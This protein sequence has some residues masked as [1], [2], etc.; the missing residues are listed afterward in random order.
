MI[1]IISGDFFN[2]TKPRISRYF[3]KSHRFLVL[4]RMTSCQQLRSSLCNWAFSN[5]FCS[6][7]AVMH[8]F[9]SFCRSLQS[10]WFTSINYFPHT[11]HFQKFL[12]PVFRCDTGSPNLSEI[13]C[14]TSGPSPTNTFYLFHPVEAHHKA[15]CVYLFVG[16]GQEFVTADNKARGNS[17]AAHN[18]ASNSCSP[19]FVCL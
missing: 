11:S 19:I 6:C 14:L 4:E 8:N 17:V 13:Q 10:G 7:C 5:I 15:V 2:K 16:S 12:R 1:D 18:V 3:F 9:F